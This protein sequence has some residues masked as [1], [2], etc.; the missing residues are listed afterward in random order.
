MDGWE[1]PMGTVLRV[2]AE[3]EDS[4]DEPGIDI[5]SDLII[6]QGDLEQA[7][8]FAAEKAAVEILKYESVVTISNSGTIAQSIKCAGNLG[9]AGTLY[10]G[11]SRPALEGRNLVES[12]IKSRWGFK[13]VFGSDNEIMSLVPNVGA[14]FVGADLIS[15]SFFVN[16][17]GTSAMSALIS[18]F[19]KMYVVA[20]LSKYYRIPIEYIKPINNPARQL[21]PRHPRR[22]EIIN[23]YFETIYFR[24]NMIFVNEEGYWNQDDIKNFLENSDKLK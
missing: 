12:L 19:R 7:M 10:V 1:P 11:E 2:R 24:S 4:V 16:K 23:R 6:I 21:W 14:A 15:N 5:M 20:D 22:V 18:D 13:I 3:I 9:W 17:T 8:T